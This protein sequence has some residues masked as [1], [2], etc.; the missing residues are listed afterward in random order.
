MAV[1]TVIKPT[2][3]IHW[4]KYHNSTTAQFARNTEVSKCLWQYLPK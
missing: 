1:S 4:T 3:A 2:K